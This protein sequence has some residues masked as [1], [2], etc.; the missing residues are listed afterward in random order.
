MILKGK[1]EVLSEKPVPVRLSVCTD[2][3]QTGMWSHSEK[4][5]QFNCY[6]GCCKCSCYSAL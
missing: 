6:C 1:T 2:P 4:G 5:V 3:A